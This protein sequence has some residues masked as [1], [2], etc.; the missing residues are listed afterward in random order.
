MSIE[1]RTE[2]PRAPRE[3]DLWLRIAQIAAISGAIA[4][5]MIAYCTVSNYL[6]GRALLYPLTEVTMSSLDK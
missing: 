1:V 4:A 3:P 5:W 6:N 2:G